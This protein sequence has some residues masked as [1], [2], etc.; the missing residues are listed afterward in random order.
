MN[1]P[2]P[3][4]DLISQ[5]ML[6]PGIGRKTAERLTLYVFSNMDN[7]DCQRFGQSFINIK[8]SCKPCKI[9]GNL[10]VNETC[11]ICSNNERDHTQVMVVESVKDLYVI[12]K[13]EI[14]KGVYHILGGAIDFTNGIGVDDIRINELIDRV[15]S[16]TIKE[17]VLATNAT[18]QGET[19]AR[20]IK[21]LLEGENVLI[22]RLA[23]GLPVGADLSYADEVTV[24][25]S[26]E[27]RLK[28]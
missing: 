28:Y 12:E 23:H 22:T 7:K 15:K 24:L 13:L 10:S 4:E 19:T 2:K 25:K 3:I 14:Y 11:E 1:Y 6:L 9:C 26:F 20:Y 18:L 27:G 16:G 5:F 8:A 21:T 17:L